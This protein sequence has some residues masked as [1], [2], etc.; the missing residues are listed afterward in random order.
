MIPSLGAP[1]IGRL[2]SQG[3][4][5][6]TI[7]GEDGKHENKDDSNDNNNN[8][9]LTMIDIHTIADSIGDIARASLSYTECIDNLLNHMSDALRTPLAINEDK[10]H[11][12]ECVQLAQSMLSSLR[13]EFQLPT[14]QPNHTI[15]TFS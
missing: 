10:K 1:V 6:I 4:T 7:H 15:T 13:K 11:M 9:K 8:E 5:R 3:E 12:S 2:E 14:L